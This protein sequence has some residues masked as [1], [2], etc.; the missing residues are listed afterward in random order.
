MRHINNLNGLYGITDPALLA[1]GQ[2]IEAVEA[3]LR[4]GLRLLQYRNKGAPFADQRK[5]CENLLAL[6]QQYG[7]TLLINDDP[8]L[9]KIVNA[10]GVHLGQSDANLSE[11]RQLLGP[12]AIIG[13]TCHNQFDYAIKASTQGADYCAFGR[14]FPSLTKPEAPPCELSVLQQARE[15]GL[16]VVAI[17]GI[18]LDNV[19][20]VLAH[21]AQ[22][23]AVIH[24]LFGQTDI[25]TTSRQFQS[26]FQRSQHV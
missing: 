3:A 2:L 26:K 9:C 7:A 6:C 19:D 18:T 15:E 17:G 13:V 21:G 25:E 12:E 23:V 4:G 1:Q 5:E 8:L 11:A 24:G 10:H 22:M 20:Q 14:C 16:R